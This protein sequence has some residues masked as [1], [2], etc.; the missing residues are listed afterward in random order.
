MRRF[1]QSQSVFRARCRR[2]SRYLEALEARHALTAEGL[3]EVA[4]VAEVPAAD[5]VPQAFVAT[6]EFITT[7]E[8]GGEE[9]TLYYKPGLEPLYA[10]VQD[11][12]GRPVSETLS[13]DSDGDEQYDLTQVTEY[14]YAGSQIGVVRVAEDHGNDGV[15]DSR[16][17]TSYTYSDAGL[18]T[19]S[20]TTIDSNADGVTDKSYGEDIT[21]DAQGNF[22]TSVSTEDTDGDGV[23]NLIRTSATKYNDNGSIASAVASVDNEGDGIVDYRSTDTYAYDSEGNAVSL[24][25]E[26]DSNGD[27]TIDETFVNGLTMVYTFDDVKDGD[28]SGEIWTTTGGVDP[29]VIREPIAIED[30]MPMVDPIAIMDPPVKVDD[31]R[32]TTV[33]D[34]LG[35]ILSESVD[36]DTDGDGVLDLRTLVENTYDGDTLTSTRYSEDQGADGSFN[37]VTTTYY[38]VNAA[39][40]PLSIL[41]ESDSD[42]DGTVDGRSSEAFTYDDTGLIVTHEGSSDKSGDGQAKSTFAYHYAYTALGNMASA[43]AVF[44][45]DGDGTTDSATLEE[46]AYNEAGQPLTLTTHTDENGDGVYDQTT[47]SDQTKVYQPVEGQETGDGDTSEVVTT[48]LTPGGPETQKTDN[49]NEIQTTGTGSSMMGDVNGDLHFDSSDLLLL[50]QSGKYEDDIA[51]N[52]NWETGDWNGDG[53]FDNSDLVLA[54]QQGTYE[55]RPG[56]E[57]VLQKSESSAEADES[58]IHNQGLETESDSS[59]GVSAIA[60]QPVS[61][62]GHQGQTASDAAQQWSAA[63]DSLWADDQASGDESIA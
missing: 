34:D 16:T 33:Q 27:G 3:P 60:Q 42:G 63:V 57:V 39:G 13:W 24:T 14:E 29:R 53:E 41:V 26:I 50:F 55:S 18:L 11:D 20:T 36:Y 17:T 23:P 28:G 12:Q 2:G 62:A 19:A 25:T 51:D 56:D 40:Q 31:S 4:V 7:R 49:N 9:P 44:D 48:V 46:Y 32:V 37:Y 22:L 6:Q 38:T 47:V 5:E 61:I 43:H 35:R 59:Y 8:I 45:H 10:V 58:G 1:F 52:A 15:V 21:Y 30:P 54:M